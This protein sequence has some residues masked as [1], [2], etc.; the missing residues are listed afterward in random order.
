MFHSALKQPQSNFIRWS[1]G[2]VIGRLAWMECC[3]N[4]LWM[5]KLLHHRSEPANTKKHSGFHFETDFAP[6]HSVRGGEGSQRRQNGTPKNLARTSSG[7]IDL[8]SLVWH[9]GLPT[10]NMCVFFLEDFKRKTTDLRGPTLKRHTRMVDYTLLGSLGLGKRGV[11]TPSRT[12]DDPLCRTV[13][14]QTA[15]VLRRTL[16]PWY[17]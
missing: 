7:V 13:C 10:K 16:Q 2:D 3:S 14:P 15:F 11:A 4:V 5:D 9:G 12:K 1:F 6:I 8:F 17:E